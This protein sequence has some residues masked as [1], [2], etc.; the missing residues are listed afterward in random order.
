MNNIRERNDR[1]FGC[2]SVVLAGAVFAGFAA[3]E[4]RAVDTPY[5][6]ECRARGV[7]IPPDWAETGTPWVLQGELT[8]NLL[9]PGRFAGVWTYSHPTIRGACIALP[10][11]SGAVGTLAGFICQSATTGHACFWDNTKRGES[12][13]LGWKGKTIVI[14]ELQDGSNLQENCTSCHKGNN[15]FLISPDDPTWKKV[16]KGPLSG[17][18]TGTFTTRVEA[19]ADNQGTPP[20]PRYIPITTQPPRPDWANRFTP[21]GCGGACHEPAAVDSPPMPPACANA[22]NGVANCF[23]AQ[24]PVG[25]PAAGSLQFSAAAYPAIEENGN[26]VISVARTGS[27]TGPVSVDYTTGGGTATEG[28][29]YTFTQGTLTWPGGDAANKT[30]SVQIRDDG[31]IEGLESINLTL[32]NPGGTAVLGIPR[33]AILTIAASDGSSASFKCGGRSVTANCTVNGVAGRP[34]A[35]TPLNDSIVGTGG[36]DVI[37]GLRGND[38]IISMAGNDY[39]CGGEGM[40]NLRASGGNDRL[41][42]ALGNDRLVGA[43]GSDICD[44]GPG[45]DRAESCEVRRNIP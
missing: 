13:P 15:V 3:D 22:P 16:L 34:C 17:P 26:V 31:D 25:E 6:S 45:R 8:E 19:S 32:S 39:V 36:A 5:M 4:A 37:Q 40:D 12:T 10:R 35:G 38:T 33:T 27:S 23:L 2:Y 43:L 41:F 11:D 24:G 20:H 14:S 44:G 30:F 18:F 7:P 29:D 1:R 9:F 21:G 28:A 42:G